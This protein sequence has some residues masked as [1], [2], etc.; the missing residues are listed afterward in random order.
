MCLTKLG[1][2]VRVNVYIGFGMYISRHLAHLQTLHQRIVTTEPVGH[3]L[4]ELVGKGLTSLVEYDAANSYQLV[5]GLSQ[6]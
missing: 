2:N 4:S 5:L 1:W 3:E 6:Q